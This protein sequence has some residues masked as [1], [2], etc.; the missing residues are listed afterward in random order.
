[1]HP[2]NDKSTNVPTSGRRSSSK[3]IS[4]GKEN[5]SSTSRTGSSKSMFVNESVITIDSTRDPGNLNLTKINVSDGRVL[6]IN[7]IDA[8]N[9]SPQKNVPV[10]IPS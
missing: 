6:S 7:G 10:L 3:S 2:L 5:A 4:R 1:M 8:I 9:A